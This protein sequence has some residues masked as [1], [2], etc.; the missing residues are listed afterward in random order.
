[1]AFDGNIYTSFNSDI[2]L[3]IY[4]VLLLIATLIDVSSIGLQF[5]QFSHL[6]VYILKTYLD[7]P[8]FW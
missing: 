3:D 8:I 6:K 4:D 7:K 1:M 2:I 5:K